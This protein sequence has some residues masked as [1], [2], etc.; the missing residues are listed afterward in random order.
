MGSTQEGGDALKQSVSSLKKK[1]WVLF[2]R[3]I[4]LRDC[5]FTTGTRTHGKCITCDQVSPI[6]RLQAGHFIAG[7]HNSYLFSEEGVHAQ[8]GHCNGALEGNTLKYR[9]A[10]IDLYGDGYDEVLEQESREIKKFTVSE[11]EDL[12]TELQE[13]IKRLEQVSR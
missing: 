10:I 4:R 3:Y 13:R 11:L 12:I 9:R 8:C 2:S 5:L 1:V 6:E 7:R